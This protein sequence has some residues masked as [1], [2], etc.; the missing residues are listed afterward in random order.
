MRKGYTLILSTIAASLLA[1]SAMAMGPTISGVP[2]VYITQNTTNE[3]VPD[4]AADANMFRFSDALSLWDY[5]TTGSMDANAPEDI[6]WAYAIKAADYATKE[7]AGS[8]LTGTAVHYQI[9]T[10]DAIA[11]AS[12]E[13][14]AAWTAEINAAAT[15]SLADADPLTFRN[16]RLSPLPD[17]V[18]YPAPTKDP[19]TLP[20]NVLDF[21]EA[22]L[23]VTD[24]SSTPTKDTVFL[25]TLDG[26]ADKLSMAGPVGPAWTNEKTYSNFNETANA[27][28][29]WDSYKLD[30]N[31]L[32]D[33]ASLT[34]TKTNTRLSIVT[35][36]NQGATSWPYGQFAP[37]GANEFAV[38]AAGKDKLY[39]FQANVGSTN[40]NVAQNPMVRLSLNGR[41]QGP[42]QASREFSK[43]SGTGAETNGPTSAAVTPYA[44]YLWP[45]ATGTFAPTF[46]VYDDEITRGGTIF[47]DAGATLDSVAKADFTGGTVVAD[48]GAGASAGFVSGTG[49]GQWSAQAVPFTGIFG[50]TGSPTF[51]SSITSN[52]M[53]LGVTGT[54]AAGQSGYVKYGSSSL[55]TTQADKLYVVKARVAASTNAGLVPDL[56]IFVSRG[57]A[58]AYLLQSRNNTQNSGPTTTP[59]DFVCVIETDAKSAGLWDLGLEVIAEPGQ[60]GNLQISRITVEEYAKPE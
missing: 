46:L 14:T 20:D 13:G 4:I 42:G 9:G 7:A 27:L 58:V 30:V 31:T 22:S 28:P 1:V 47:I 5:V 44:V 40:A 2:D 59:K 38:D 57:N 50:Y 54:V 26:G 16:I 18:P 11:P 52:L 55:F 17:A 10:I 19:A 49:N 32:G 3:A 23:F 25:I 24:G 53:T 56:R 48:Q 8:F 60:A 21:Q 41:T 6:Y 15:Q 36:V 51:T 34:F 35:T 37:P 33:P 12:T 43:G 39:R 29:M 45:S